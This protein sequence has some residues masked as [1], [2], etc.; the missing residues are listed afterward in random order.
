M[1]L[2]NGDIGHAEDLRNQLYTQFGQ[3]GNYLRFERGRQ[4]DAG[5]AVDVL[6]G[7]LKNLDGKYALLEKR[8]C[9]ACHPVH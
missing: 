2:R 5:E 7:Q 1:R 3:V 4:N 6:V 8:Q 9:S